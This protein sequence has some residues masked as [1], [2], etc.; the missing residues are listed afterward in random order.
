[1]EITAGGGVVSLHQFILG[2]SFACLLASFFILAGRGLIYPLNLFHQDKIIYYGYYYFMG[3][4][5]FLVFVKIFAKVGMSFNNSLCLSFFVLLV[6]SIIPK[7][8]GMVWHIFLMSAARVIFVVFMIGFSA[9]LLLNI[10]AKSR[11]GP[12][13]SELTD[14]ILTMNSLPLLNRHHAQSILA[15]TIL[16][17]F[18]KQDMQLAK[19]GVNLWLPI[20]QA[21][22]LLIIYSLIANT[23]T[24]MINRL[25]VCIV[26]FAGNCALSLLPQIPIDHDFPL[27]FNVYVDSIVG[28]GIS[29]MIVTMSVYLL[30][31]PQIKTWL[32]LF[33]TG[34]LYLLFTTLN[35]TSELNIFV[36]AVSL[37]SAFLMNLWLQK[38][39]RVFFIRSAIFF[40]TITL[41]LMSSQFMGGIFM[42]KDLVSVMDSTNAALF[43]DHNANTSMGKIYASKPAQWYLPFLTPGFNKD[44]GNYESILDAEIVSKRSLNQVFMN[45]GENYLTTSKLAR[46][47]Y[48][49]EM[50]VT[51]V[52]KIL[53]WPILACIGCLYLLVRSR[54]NISVGLTKSGNIYGSSSILNTKEGMSFSVTSFLIGL[55]V[56]FVNSYPGD[57]FYWKWAL[58]RLNELGIFLMMIY[59]G[60][61]LMYFHSKIKT[62]WLRI[63][64]LIGF[65]SLFISGVMIRLLAYTYFDG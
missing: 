22:L 58:T 38:N 41:A 31:K 33:T 17:V 30:N 6:I 29:I 64:L 28:L 61:F 16:R 3:I 12:I 48:L 4:C 57:A 7:I 65:I 62:H 9:L 24:K 23:T 49:I 46:I 50:R 11:G 52:I 18:D 54:Q 37:L 32:F 13:Y 25:I 36:I 20:S 63:L 2:G 51:T 1:M 5:P 43:D 60:I 55:S 59:V 21:F 44:F 40:V 19:M 8:I 26:A 10:I 35:L 27:I 42:P 14:Y 15:A 56:I 53:F 34:L 39:I 45:M 47:V